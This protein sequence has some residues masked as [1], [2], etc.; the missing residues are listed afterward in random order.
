MVLRKRRGNK[1]IQEIIYVYSLFVHLVGNKKDVDREERS[2]WL[3]FI[4]VLY[5]THFPMVKVKAIP[6]EG[7][8]LNVGAAIS[9]HY[10]FSLVIQPNDVHVRFVQIYFPSYVF[11]STFHPNQQT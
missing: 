3:Y 2:P 4:L 11:H 6:W 7:R 10:L 8:N 1:K 9:V 5:A